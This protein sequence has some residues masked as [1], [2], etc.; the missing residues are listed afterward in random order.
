MTTMLSALLEGRCRRSFSEKKSPADF[1]VRSFGGSDHLVQWF[2][3]DIVG[4]QE[5]FEVKD[6]AKTTGEK[7]H[8]QIPHVSLTFSLVGILMRIQRTS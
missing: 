5:V 6:N 2:F 8:R 4:S 1:N 7:N 3:H